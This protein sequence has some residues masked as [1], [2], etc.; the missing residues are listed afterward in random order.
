MARR[1]LEA[2]LKAGQAIDEGKELPEK[3]TKVE[4]LKEVEVE[5]YMGGVFA[6]QYNYDGTVLAVG[7]RGG[8][9]RLYDPITGE[10]IR[11]LR[12]NR[13]GGY[14]IMCLRYHPKEPHLLFAGTAEGHVYCY[15]TLTGDANH[16]ITEQGNE[17][18]TL[19]FCVDGYLYAT[20]GKDLAVR[21]YHTKNN[22]LDKTYEGYRKNTELQGQV[23]L[24]CGNTMRVYALKFSP[25]N[26]DIFITAGWDNHIKIWDVRTN[27]GIK[28][29]IHGPHVCGDALDMRD[30]HIL[31]GSW[32]AK[33]ALQVFDYGE[34][35]LLQ[36]IEFP[37]KNGAF[38][39]S[40][41]FCD[42]GVVL[43]GGSGTN[44]AEA[45]EVSPGPKRPNVDVKHIGGVQMSKPVQA[46]DSANGGRLFAVGSGDNIIKLCAMT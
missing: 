35:T 10:L 27:D 32:C 31:A 17:I 14:S 1:V 15:N 42:N 37:A 39:Y 30:K 8:G 16:I 18:N 24:E 45:L 11:E 28:R 21:V 36:D 40:A 2:A 41:Q 44:S 23:D 20:A 19:D 7:F 38:L 25:D 33:H 29:Q 22:K 5:K 12:A 13:H 34:G 4:V 43:A 3:F 26:E 46:I 9:V 6:L